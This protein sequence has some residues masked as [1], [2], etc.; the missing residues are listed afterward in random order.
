[1][2]YAARPGGVP[3]G[4]AGMRQPAVEYICA[5]CS[6]I[7]EIRPREPIRCR[8]CGHR[9]MYKKRTKHMLHFEAR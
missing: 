1:M 3:L 7:N 4:G 5:D 9:I 2:S 8:E 6:A